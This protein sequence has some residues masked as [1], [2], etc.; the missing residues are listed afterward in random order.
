MVGLCDRL[1]RFD[2]VIVVTVLPPLLSFCRHRRAVTTTAFTL[3]ISQ[4]DHVEL[5]RERAWLPPGWNEMMIGWLRLDVVVVVAATVYID[6]TFA[7]LMVVL[8]R[9][10]SIL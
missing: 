10:N 8:Y 9:R 6:G 4:V 3:S 2:V 1:R 7:S 5:W